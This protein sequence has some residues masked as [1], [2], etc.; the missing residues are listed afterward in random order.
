MLKMR[1]RIYGGRILG[2][3][4]RGYRHRSAGDARSRCLGTI[5]ADRGGQGGSS[6]GWFFR[7]GLTDLVSLETGLATPMANIWVL[8]EQVHLAAGRRQYANYSIWDTYR[9]WI[10]PRRFLRVRAR[11]R[12]MM[13]SLAADAREMAAPRRGGRSANHETGT[14]GEGV[15]P[16]VCSRR[17]WGYQFQGW[18][19][20]SRSCRVPEPIPGMHCQE[21]QGARGA[22]RFS[23]PGYVP[24]GR[25]IWDDRRQLHPPNTCMPHLPCKMAESL[26]RNDQV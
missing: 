6:D 2:L 5:E 1:R 10:E 23:G 26:G 24:Q 4:F 13:E 20:A 11:R 17:I 18:V 3:G 15:T 25:G 22:G 19:S 12:D 9:T 8:M 21:T 7:P 16:P 14:G